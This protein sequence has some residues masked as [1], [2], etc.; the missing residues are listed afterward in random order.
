MDQ[1][2]V[3]PGIVAEVDKGRYVSVRYKVNYV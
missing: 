1:Q 3:S 2:T